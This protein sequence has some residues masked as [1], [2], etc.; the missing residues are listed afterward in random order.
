MKSF[1]FD[2]I[3]VYIKKGIL[4]IEKWDKIGSL[5]LKEIKNKDNII[6]KD[7]SV[8]LFL[9]FLIINLF[10]DSWSENLSI[11][12]NSFIKITGKTAKQK[13]GI[14]FN[15]YNISTSDKYIQPLKNIK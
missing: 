9:L 13:N 1:F 15:I 7:K 12:I 2:L 6:T 5:I 14:Y 4:I 10:S 3:K 8:I 11:T